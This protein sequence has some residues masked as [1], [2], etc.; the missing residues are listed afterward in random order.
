MTI[1]LDSFT[2]PSGV[3]WL[4]QWE[5]K[6]IVGAHSTL[7]TGRALFE[8]NEIITGLPITLATIDL[9]N[10]WSGIF[11]LDESLA[12]KALYNATDIER[13]LT[14]NDETFTVRFDRTNN[15]GLEVVPLL[16]VS[17]G[18]AWGRAHLFRNRTV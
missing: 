17:A 18:E 10:K 7:L 5:V 14:I 2:F 8:T 15:K 4:D 1:T 6:P 13:T 9:G 12:L 16:P 11:S 3:S